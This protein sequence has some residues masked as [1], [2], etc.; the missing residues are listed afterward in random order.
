MI[1]ETRGGSAPAQPLLPLSSLRAAVAARECSRRLQHERP[2]RQRGHR[3]TC[4]AQRC[5]TSAS[6]LSPAPAVTSASRSAV[7]L[8]PPQT[9]RDPSVRWRTS[10]RTVPGTRCVFRVRRCSMERCLFRWRARPSVDGDRRRSQRDDLRRRRWCSPTRS[11][12]AAAAGVLQT[13]ASKS[14][15]VLGPGRS[16]PIPKRTCRAVPRVRTSP[17][18]SRH[19]EPNHRA[20][21]IV[22][23]SPTS[24]SGSATSAAP[25]TNR[26]LPVFIPGRRRRTRV[27]TRA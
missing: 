25:L 9:V 19:L 26:G 8:H 17:W 5:D 3:H 1:V 14:A 12:G 15:R 10:C 23:L 20:A 24:D 13:T 6:P 7:G 4:R 21:L 16:E 2:Q 18:P 27:P 11:T 22:R